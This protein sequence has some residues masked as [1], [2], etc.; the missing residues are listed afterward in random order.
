MCDFFRCGFDYYR[1]GWWF[2][3]ICIIVINK[4]FII[5]ATY[6]FSQYNLWIPI[7]T[8]MDI[9][10]YIIY[11][12]YYNINTYIYG[13][14]MYSFGIYTQFTVISL[15]FSHQG[16]IWCFM[17]LLCLCGSGCNVWKTI[18][19]RFHDNNLYFRE[20]FFPMNLLFFVSG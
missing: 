12:V 3:F 20:F 1:D 19:A 13:E 2:L 4:I 15:L 14:K 6:I 5:C 7:P 9:Y 10:T 16:K 8:Y 17:Y 11:D 18:S